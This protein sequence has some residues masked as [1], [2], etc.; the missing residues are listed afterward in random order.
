MSS[1][2]WR[3]LRYWMT[4]W[5]SVMTVTVEPAPASDGGQPEP[6]RGSIRSGAS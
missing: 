3:L 5:E 4:I 2:T 1:M 6:V